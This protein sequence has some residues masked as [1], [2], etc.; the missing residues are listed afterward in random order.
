[1][2]VKKVAADQKYQVES[3]YQAVEQ[4]FSRYG[5]NKAQQQMGHY[6]L[7]EMGIRKIMVLSDVL[8]H[9]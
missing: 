7:P 5:L 8:L 6:A 1:M 9:L 2:D 3:I 4:A